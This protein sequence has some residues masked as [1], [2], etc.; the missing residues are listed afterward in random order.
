M[1]Q[2]VIDLARATVATETDARLIA[3]APKLLAALQAI[4]EAMTAQDTDRSDAD[5]F[6]RYTLV[7]QQARAAIAE[8]TEEGM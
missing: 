2:K 8:A 4:E 1:Q 7:A 6:H 3:A 5:R